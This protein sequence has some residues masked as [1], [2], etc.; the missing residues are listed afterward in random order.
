[1]ETRTPQPLSTPTVT[2]VP[3]PSVPP[4]AKAEAI[5]QQRYVSEHSALRQQIAV[6]FQRATAQKNRLRRA[7]KRL[8]IASLVLS[9]LATF[10][11]GES[12]LAGEP[13]MGDWRFTTTVA[14]V[15]TLS[16]T[17]VAG[18]HKQVAPTD[19]IIESSEFS[20]KLKALSIEALPTE[21]NLAEVRQAYQQLI[22]EFSEVDS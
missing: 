6:S 8:S 1:M 10:I 7:D 5:A 14:S 20:A 17:L 13:I 12:A 18:I 2:A 22:A 9:A 16:A 19:L 11:A 3:S 21:Y 15:C 4:A